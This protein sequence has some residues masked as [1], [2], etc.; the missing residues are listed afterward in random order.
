MAG[1]EKEITIEELLQQVAAAQLQFGDDHPMRVL[2]EQCRVAIIF[3]AQ[4][5][6]QGAL[7]TRGGL[8][9]Q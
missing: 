5:V 6:P 1:N 8:V 2:L 4:R 3:L 7:Q 9:L